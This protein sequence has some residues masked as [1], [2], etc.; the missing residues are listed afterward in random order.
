MCIFR[1]S[2]LHQNEGIF[3]CPSSRE[4]HFVR[5]GVLTGFFCSELL[6]FRAH[7]PT[8]QGRHYSKNFKRLTLSQ[9]LHFYLFLLTLLNAPTKTLAMMS[10]KLCV[11]WDAFKEDLNSTFQRLRADKEFTDVTLACED[12]QQMEA[13]KVILAASSAFFEK[14]LLDRKHP[15]P[16]IYLKGFQ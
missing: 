6:P 11:Q 3:I 14:I 10:Q 5:E 9:H 16:L 8:S 7:S 15:H 2:V 1:T 13:H 4:R 12:G